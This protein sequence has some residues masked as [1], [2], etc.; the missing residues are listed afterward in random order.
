MPHNPDCPKC[1]G[2]GEYEYEGDL[3]KSA[4]LYPCRCDWP[5]APA[6]CVFSYILFKWS[7]NIK[8][9]LVLP[10]EVAASLPH[11]FPIPVLAVQGKYERKVFVFRASSP[12]EYFY[13]SVDGT[14]VLIEH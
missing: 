5:V 10:H 2:T 1:H 6:H 8:E 7:P 11:D 12:K 4:G 9:V 3:H 14:T 13:E